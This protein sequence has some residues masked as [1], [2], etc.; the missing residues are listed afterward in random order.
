MVIFEE[1]KDDYHDIFSLFW[2]LV[3]I[4]IWAIFGVLIDY[5]GGIN[6]ELNYP[7]YIILVI[8]FFWGI[9]LLI[10]N[11]KRCISNLNKKKFIFDDHSFTIK[12][13]I[14]KKRYEYSG[15]RNVSINYE[16]IAFVYYDTQNT[17]EIKEYE[18]A[19]NVAAEI[20]KHLKAGDMA[21]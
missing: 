3:L 18:I 2:F 14:I 9:I 21:D 10:A 6:S 17:I 4:T 12:H 1:T 19:Y 8:G 20:E 13:F 7:F 11:L 5:T 16:F 15:L